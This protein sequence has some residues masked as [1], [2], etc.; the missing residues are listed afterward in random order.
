MTTPLYALMGFVFWT[1][2]LVFAI[3]ASRVTEVA[4][5]KKAPTDFPAG[6]PHGDPRYWRMNRAH[7]NCLENL[8]LFAAVVLAGHVSGLTEGT[9]ALLSQVYMAARVGQ[10]CVHIASGSVLAVNVRFGFFLAQMACLV[11][12]AWMV[13]SR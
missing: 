5:G 6:Q 11:T 4:S 9:F 13:V 3:G 8:P 7:M 1:V 10:S 2:F 12:M